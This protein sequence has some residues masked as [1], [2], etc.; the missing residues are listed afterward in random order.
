MNYANVQSGV[1]VAVVRGANS[2]LLTR[3]ITDQLAQERKVL[4]GAAERKE[5]CY[6]LPK[7]IICLAYVTP[8]NLQ[9]TSRLVERFVVDIIREVKLIAVNYWKF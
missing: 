5:V 2:P 9:V 7:L 4:E 8:N 6:V 3:V 1:L